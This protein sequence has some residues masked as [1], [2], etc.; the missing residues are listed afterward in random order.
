MIIDPVM[1]MP[2]AEGYIDRNNPHTI[3]AILVDD[4]GRDEVLLLVTDSGNVCGYHVE[5]IYSCLTRC[6]EEGI[7]RPLTVL[8]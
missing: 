6:N 2:R 8:R 3:N 4:L 1:K 5:A 7:K